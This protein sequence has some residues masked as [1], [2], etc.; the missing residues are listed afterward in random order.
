MATY[1]DLPS[2]DALLRHPRVQAGRDTGSQPR[3]VIAARQALDEARA[4]VGEGR[5]APSADAL[6]E[7]LLS[8]A[9][10]ERAPHLRPV[11]N[12]SGVILQTNLGRSPLSAAAL[13]AIA[14]VASG[15]SNLEY[16]LERGARGGR[17]AG[18]ARLIPAIT[19]AGAGF[20][21]NNNASAVLLALA[22]LAAGRDVLVSRGQLVEIGGGFR[23]PD[24][25][26]QSGAHL[27]EVGTTNRTYGRDF[28]AAITPATAVIL[29]V[30]P[31]NFVQHGFTHQ[32]DLVEL[33]ELAH[34]H[35]IL[36]IDDLGSGALLDTTIA[37]IAREPTVQESVAAGA[38]L[39][40]FSGDKLLGG[41]QSGLLAGRADL[42]ARL[43][44]HPLAR[45]V[46][47]D[48]LGLAALEAT[49]RHYLL[50]EATDALPIWR[51]L[52]R[53]PEDLARQ[54]AAWTE[55]LRAAGVPARVV[56]GESTVGGGSLPGETL[57]TSL[58]Q[59]TPPAVETVARALRIGDPAIVGRIHREAILLDPRTVAAQEEGALLDRIVTVWGEQ[60]R[61]EGPPPV[62]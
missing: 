9:A 48:K 41:P 7:R 60:R 3:L 32:P 28:A 57:P 18:S 54:A 17:Q 4:A 2:V 34:R 61:A 62:V 1:R 5:S 30:H 39:V 16:D 42:L 21:V 15:Y 53:R 43:A 20:A 37:G 23:I 22:G 52:L 36:L 10:A 31:S 50:D 46:R 56:A 11:V 26:R 47:L 12:A 25:L 35:G 38:D 27:V 55:R 24:V 13:E 33:A 51:M 8:L 59:L 40:C 45:A 58:V 14:L 19:G 29:R 49:L 6:V 44:Q